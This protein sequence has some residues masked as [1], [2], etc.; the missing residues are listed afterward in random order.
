MIRTIK[1]G[2]FIFI[3]GTFV[4]SL[5]NGKISVRIGNKTYEGEP[6]SRAA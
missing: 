6:V 3:Q 4:R 2:A 5:P 1:Q